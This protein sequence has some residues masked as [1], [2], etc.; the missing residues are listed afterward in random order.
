MLEAAQLLLENGVLL[1]AGCYLRLDVV[2]RL[3]RDLKVEYEVRK[4]T[5]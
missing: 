3:H 5:E 1:N 2:K 4:E